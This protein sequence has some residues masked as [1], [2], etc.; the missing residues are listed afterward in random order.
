M[1]SIRRK[2]KE[3]DVNECKKIIKKSKFITL[4]MCRNNMPYLVTLSHGYDSDKNFIYFHCANDGKKLEYFK[5]NKNVWGQALID[6]GYQ[7]G[8]C[9]HYYESVHFKGEVEILTNF[10]EKK[11]A[12]E[13]MI[14]SLEEDPTIVKTQ[15]L[16]QKAIE[17]VT[18]GKIRITGLSGKRSVE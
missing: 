16:T 4:A 18:I 5:A 9:N 10:Q 12:L 14:D 6:Q 13:T 7:Q 8:K 15:Q 1:R 3:I 17:N 11:I 2:E